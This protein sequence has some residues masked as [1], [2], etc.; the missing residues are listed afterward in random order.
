VPRY[1]AQRVRQTHDVWHVLTG[2]GPDVEDELALQGFTFAQ[3]GMPS[4]FLI[5]TLGTLARAPRSIARVLEGY[6][7]GKAS[8]FLPTVRFE[9]MWQRPLLDVRRE[10]RIPPAQA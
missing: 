6:R 5:A 1:V 3:M 4:S 9:A 10:L 7:R 2:Y 8:A